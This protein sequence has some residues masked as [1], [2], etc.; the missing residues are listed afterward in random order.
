MSLAEYKLT[1]GR[2]YLLD[3]ADV[4]EGAELV[5]ANAE[6]TPVILFADQ[7]APD[8]ADDTEPKQ[9]RKRANKQAEA[10]DNKLT[11]D[12]EDSPAADAEEAGE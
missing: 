7:V 9:G 5:A 10:P 11:A 3:E 6:A 1:D 2:T 12:D 4:P 8:S